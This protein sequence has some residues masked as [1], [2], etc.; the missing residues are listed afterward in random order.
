ME[1]LRIGRRRVA[2]D[3]PAFVIA[4]AGV[5]HNGRRD[6]ALALVD[7]AAAAGADAVKFQKRSPRDL[8]TR[9]GYDAPYDNGGHSHGRTYGE[10]REKIELSVDDHLALRDRAES[11]GIAYLCSAWDRPSLDFVDELGV[12][13]HKIASPDCANLPYCTDVAKRG[14]PILLS[15]GMSEPWEVE[16]AVREIR[17]INPKL[18]LLHCVSIYP[19][20]SEA[21]HLRNLEM[22]RDRYQLPVGFS[23]HE[24]GW[25]QV[26]AARTLGACVIEKHLTLD[27]TQKGGDHRFSL[28][29][30]GF[31][32]MV[33]QLRAV[34]AALTPG[35]KPLLDAERR[36]RRKLGK[37][38][39]VRTALP[40]GTQLT[41]R[42][43]VCRSPATGLSPSWIGRVVGQRLTRALPAE[44][45]LEPE[46]L[47][48]SSDDGG[49]A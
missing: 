33:R 42:H 19:T 6:G 20:P 49:G 29:P 25:H 39:C 14:K 17:A 22:L 46:H 10:H 34:E 27:R 7:A 16:A 28:E 18:A 23:G 35:D 5:N 12:A 37:S 45:P 13:A 32:A 15:T 40:A 30:D 4:E 24:E 47:G 9:H 48:W 3:E 2:A 1:S 43:L 36:F 21:L 11:H 8:L 38:L 44:A 41:E 31:A 26:I